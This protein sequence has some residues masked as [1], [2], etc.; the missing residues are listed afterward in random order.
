MAPVSA[1]EH[2][3]RMQQSLTSLHERI[4]SAMKAATIDWMAAQAQFEVL[5]PELDALAREHDEWTA[6]YLADMRELFGP[7][8]DLERQQQQNAAGVRRWI[9]QDHVH[10]LLGLA[11]TEQL[12][13]DWPAAERSLARASG[14]I[15]SLAIGGWDPELVAQQLMVVSQQASVY[16]QLAVYNDGDRALVA[17]A[18]DCALR[19][20]KQAESRSSWFIAIEASMLAASCAKLQDDT[21]AFERY[22]QRGLWLATAHEHEIGHTGDIP[23]LP[24]YLQSWITTMQAGPDR[25]GE[26]ALR[27]ARTNKVVAADVYRQLSAEVRLP[28]RRCVS[29]RPAWGDDKWRRSGTRVRSCSTP[30]RRWCG[31]T[32]PRRPRKHWRGSVQRRRGSPSR[33]WTCSPARRISGSGRATRP[34]LCRSASGP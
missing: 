3:G 31:F 26:I 6:A 25:T 11:A 29:G 33:S 7:G 32:A 18:L 13:E 21:A 16:V 24:R 4:G 14:L 27:A 34:P 19:A 12:T 17:K 8:S 15:D 9:A 2:Y 20:G 23:S 30:C 22:S 1:T 10:V 5:M 28:G